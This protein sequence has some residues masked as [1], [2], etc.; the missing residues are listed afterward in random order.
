MCAAQDEFAPAMPL[1]YI[2]AKSMAI[3]A[4]ICI[5]TNNNIVMEKIEG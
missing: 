1:E 3:A 4:E 5:Y 2:V